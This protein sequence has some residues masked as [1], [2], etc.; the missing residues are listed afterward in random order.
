MELYFLHDILKKVGLDPSLLQ[1]KLQAL[2]KGD[3]RRHGNITG[4]RMKKM[5]TGKGDMM[6]EEIGGKT[7]T[8]RTVLFLRGQGCNIPPACLGYFVFLNILYLLLVRS[9]RP[10]PHEKQN[11]AA[12]TS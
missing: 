5:K 2:N 9:S 1:E 11:R 7:R 10:R 12:Y 8:P 3:L 4:I 6:E